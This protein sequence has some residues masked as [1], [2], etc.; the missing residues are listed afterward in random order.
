MSLVSL[1]DA[2]DRV[3][4]AVTQDQ[5]DEVEDELRGLIGPLVG[6]RTE[7][8]YLSEAHHPWRPI[9]GLYLSRRTDAV[10]LT[11]ASTG[12][13]PTT[14]TSGTDF[15][16]LDHFLIERI[17]AGATWLSILAAVY[18]PNDEE[19][20]RGIIFD[21]LTYRQTPAGIQ[22]IRIGA[23]SETYFPSGSSGAAQ[24]HSPVL[25]AFLRRVLPM[26]GLGITSPFRRAAARR[27]RTLIAGGDGS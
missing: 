7:T 18:T 4:D 12:E 19:L 26:A 14:L 15:R 9:D 5:L 25:N 1:S 27:D 16:L 11:N 24:A 6:E 2:T 10:S 22:S 21:W 23:Y 3:G 13:S 17:P 8:F 20:V